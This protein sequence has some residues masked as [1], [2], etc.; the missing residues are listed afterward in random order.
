M[1]SRAQKDKLRSL[2]QDGQL[3][4]AAQQREWTLSISGM[5]DDKGAPGRSVSPAELKSWIARNGR[6]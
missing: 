4:T 1:Y 2:L 6:K 5:V 3:D